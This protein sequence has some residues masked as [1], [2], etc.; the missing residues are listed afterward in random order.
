MLSSSLYIFITNKHNVNIQTSYFNSFNWE[1]SRLNLNQLLRASLILECKHLQL[2]FFTKYLPL[3]EWALKRPLL[4]YLITQLA[5]SRLSY[6]GWSPGGWHLVH[7]K[8]NIN[9]ILKK[10]VDNTQDNILLTWKSIIV[11]SLWSVSKVVG[12]SNVF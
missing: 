10:A 6:T 7:F 8:I 12:E 11:I 9:F 3:Q 1:T 4:L 5:T 2:H